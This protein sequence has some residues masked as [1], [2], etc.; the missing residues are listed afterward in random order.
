LEAI[1]TIQ[2]M[3]NDRSILRRTIADP[4]TDS[5]QVESIRRRVADLSIEIDALLSARGLLAGK[6]AAAQSS[7]KP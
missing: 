2:R 1:D 4:E 6:I 5:G 3:K 7:S